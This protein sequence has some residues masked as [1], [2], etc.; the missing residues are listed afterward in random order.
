VGRT[1]IH[2]IQPANG[3]L[4]AMREATHAVFVDQP[5]GSIAFCLSI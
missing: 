5:Q 1:K 3:S 2:G 4:E